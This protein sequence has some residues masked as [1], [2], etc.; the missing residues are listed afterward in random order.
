MQKKT[1][2][3]A[4]AAE[5]QSLGKRIASLRRLLEAAFSWDEARVALAELRE[6]LEAHFSMEEAGGYLAE[7]LAEAPERTAAV[8]K[9]ASD[10]SRMRGTLA[11]LLAEA[12]VA[13]SREDLT[14]NVHLFLVTLTDHERRENE[15]VHVTFAI[16]VAAGD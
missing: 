5:H 14:Q 16:D 3:E 10:H 11:R 4:M 9:L 2:S 12:L 13:R 7:V 8:A 6:T 15:L 1:Q